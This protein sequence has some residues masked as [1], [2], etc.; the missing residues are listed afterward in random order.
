MTSNATVFIISTMTAPV[1]Y[2]F[3]EDRDG[4]PIMKDKII[5]AGGAGIPS[6][7][8]GFGEVSADVEGRPLWTADGLVTPIPADRYEKLKEHPVFKK[9]MAKGY[10]R[11]VSTDIR[12]N[13]GAVK[14]IAADMDRD[15][16][17]LLSAKNVKARV[18]TKTP[19]EDTDDYF[20][21]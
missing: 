9:H 17:Q 14:K 15:G 1:S 2:G 7:K 12:G 21:V 6:M 3:Y 13:H 5:I 18:S 11:V 8:S 4:L 16:F 20:R 10:L 19:G